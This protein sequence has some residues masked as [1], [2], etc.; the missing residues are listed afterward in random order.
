MR[1]TGGQIVCEALLRQGVEVV[2]GL[3]GGAILPLYQTLPEY[4]QL[5]HILVRHEQ[6]AAHAAD[7]YA[8][9]TG[10]PGVAW[11]TSGPGATNLVTG[12]ATAHMDSIPI[13]IITGQVGRDAIGSDAFQETDITGITLPIT[14]HNYLVMNASELPNVIAEA[15]HI[16][17]TGRPGPVLV[18]IP[19][20][21]FQEETEVAD[22]PTINLI[23]YKP[24]IKGNDRQIRRAA[25][26]I[27][28]AERP[29]IL[30]G[31]GV[32]FSEAYDELRTLAE[33]TQMPVITTLLGI[34]CFP[35]DHVLSVGM[36]GMHGM[37]YASLAIEESDLLLAV[38]MRFDDRI[39]G[40]P[41]R[42]ATNSKKIHIEIDPSEIGKN[43]SVD[44]PI[45]GDAKHILAAL[46]KLAPT[47]T[48]PDWVKHITD[49]KKSHPS[50]DIR[51]TDKLLPQFIIKKLSMAT[52]GEAI[53]VT[54]VGQHQMWAAQFY[55]FKNPRSFITSG[56]AGS[57]GYEV[58]GAM[59][60]Q[61]G[62]P[63]K[64]VWSI[65]GDG[66]FQMTMCE[67][68][69]MVE[70]KIPVKIAII[71]NNFLGM[72]RQWQQFFYEKSYVATEY[73]HNPDFVKLAEAF[74]VLG[75]RVTKQDQVE[76][77]IKQAME[78]D[79]PVIIDFVVE[80]EENV[81]PMIPSGQTVHDM[82]EEP[83]QTESQPIS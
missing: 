66:G 29:I 54:G 36:P 51:P 41:A 25:E 48:H 77:A 12:I 30:A 71:N 8:R 34:S 22:T 21:V 23:G 37:A 7:G 38:G 24:T 46:L 49:L 47:K 44:V 82:I 10:R 83:R 80:A 14:K 2:F 16:A 13:V 62:Q 4:P 26:L 45:V 20:D 52:N 69:T 75:L 59:G 9:A 42:F 65:A 32:I 61:V 17:T 5:R 18:D 3:P 81:Y 70:N 1:R 50:L 79:G 72:V 73:S 74:G 33:K 64:T 11:A 31:H 56:G 57:M 6:G 58:P 53:I 68:A 35:E 60:V 40:D 15:F 19:K 63:D 27:Q 39:I 43:I 78:Y 55:T 28:K 67:I 76:S